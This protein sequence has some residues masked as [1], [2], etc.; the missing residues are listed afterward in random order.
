M[1]LNQIILAASTVC[2]TSAAFALTPAQV[3]GSTVRL[4]LS[5]SAALAD[6]LFR[7]VLSTCAGMRYQNNHGVYYT[8][9]GVPDVH[10]YLES[11]SA[12]KL[13]GS[14]DDRMAYTCTVDTYDGRAGSLEGQK[15]VVFHT[16]EGG[17]F[18]A[19]SPHLRIKG[20][21]NNNL[22]NS[23]GRIGNIE[24]LA[25]AGKCAASVAE[26]IN[27]DLGGTANLVKVYRGCAITNQTFTVDQALRANVFA[28]PDRPEGGYSSTEYVINQLNLNIE[29]GL[30]SIGYEIPVGI[31]QT[32]A[33]GVSW[34]LY[35][36]LQKN[37][38]A[39][40]K[41]AATCDDAPYTST[42]PNLAASCQPNMAASTYTAIANSDSIGFVDG[43][44]FGAVAT[45][46]GTSGKIQFHR[47]RN[48]SGVQS[49]SNL[50]FLN[51]PCATGVAAGALEPSRVAHSTARVK[52]LE[53]PS[54]SYVKDGLTQATNAGEF[55]LGVVSMEIFPVFGSP[56]KWAFVKLD[57]VSP[58]V[59]STGAFDYRL[60]ANAIE[61]NY[62]FWY[63]PV[64]FVAHTAFPEGAELIS[65]VN[66]AFSV[67]PTLAAGATGLFGNPSQAVEGDGDYIGKASRAGVS[68]QPAF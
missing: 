49:A 29:T 53:N 8:N 38:I 1:K 42:S 2:V 4:W 56:D 10:L 54:N 45:P 61:G 39:A 44:L 47:R 28:G 26:S 36:Q 5:G 3:D 11:V 43:T 64:S 50:R 55:G 46:P 52:V 30:D 66:M 40:G 31:G 14:V 58:N 57:G 32:F 59:T 34:P 68:C 27:I 33:V 67:P 41:I 7:G 12:N 19:Y 51:K 25:Q 13:P 20:D 22:P 9:P 6:P 62:T 16:V 60:R 63:E 37:D 35:Y 21:T 48:I 15:I 17:S 24:G 23:L 18:N 65:A